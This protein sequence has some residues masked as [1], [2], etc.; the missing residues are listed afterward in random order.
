MKKLV[1]FLFG[2]TKHIECI[3]YWFRLLKQ[4]ETVYSKK[5]YT[6]LLLIHQKGYVLWLTHVKNVL[7]E[8]EFERV[9]ML[10]CRNE[11]NFFEELRAGLQRSFYHDWRNHTE[12]SEKL[13]T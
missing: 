10:G 5:A 8:N 2:F 13:S 1:A 7:C 3:K 4:P 9:W 6:M 11:N 12:P